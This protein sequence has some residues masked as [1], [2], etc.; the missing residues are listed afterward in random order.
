MLISATDT[1]PPIDF[2]ITILAPT[3]RVQPV[4][5]AFLSVPTE[6]GNPN[7]DKL[8]YSLSGLLNRVGGQLIHP[9]PLP[10]IQHVDHYRSWNGSHSATTH[11]AIQ[12]RA[13][14]ICAAHIATRIH[15]IMH[16]TD[17][18]SDPQTTHQAPSCIALHP[19]AIQTPIST[20]DVHTT[21]L[22]L[23]ICPVK[24]TNA[25]GQECPILNISGLRVTGPAPSPLTKTQLNDLHDSLIQAYT[26]A[27]MLTNNTEFQQHAQAQSSPVSI[28][29]SGSISL[30]TLAQAYRIAT[31]ANIPHLNDTDDVTHHCLQLANS[32][33]SELHL[34]MCGHNH[35]PSLRICCRPHVPDIKVSFA[36][37]FGITTHAVFLPT[38]FLV[39]PSSSTV[40][41]PTHVVIPLIKT[42]FQLSTT[43]TLLVQR[44]YPVFVDPQDPSQTLI[45]ILQAVRREVNTTQYF[46]VLHANQF[47]NTHQLSQTT[48]TAHFAHLPIKIST[49]TGL[50]HIVHLQQQQWYLRPNEDSLP[51]DS[52]TLANTLTYP[53]SLLFPISTPLSVQSPINPTLRTYE[54]AVLSHQKQQ[55]LPLHIPPNSP[56]DKQH[57]HCNFHDTACKAEIQLAAWGS[58]IG[59]WCSKCKERRKSPSPPPQY[60]KLTDTSLDDNSFPICSTCQNRLDGAVLPLTIFGSRGWDTG[61]TY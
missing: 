24:H 26:H 9:S 58:A 7:G 53:P 42:S 37:Q 6:A 8:V 44:I 40:K 16:T 39:T 25:P 18:N 20:D 5:R 35:D 31:G 43:N 55:R 2:P 56:F 57:V 54:I 46:A 27:Q 48:T 13:P 47:S 1:S 49:A 60:Q 38:N 3:T 17:A 14:A 33:T 23:C 52:I 28:L 41:S 19:H 22:Q 34:L 21:P 4:L 15:Y 32:I 12:F 10:P 50:S 11:T 59:F 30:N 51:T 29:P 45:E 36:A 61:D